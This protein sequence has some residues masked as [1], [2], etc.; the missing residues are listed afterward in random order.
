MTEMHKLIES[1]MPVRIRHKLDRC[2]ID[3]A[4]QLASGAVVFVLELATK[5]SSRNIFD[6]R[7]YNR[8]SSSLSF[9]VWPTMSC[10][11]G[12]SKRRHVTFIIIEW[13]TVD[14]ASFDND[15]R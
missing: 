11:A 10:F 12:W 14:R 2:I 6:C 8:A 1:I 15:T 3:I 5:S 9:V 13:Y 7:T 4:V